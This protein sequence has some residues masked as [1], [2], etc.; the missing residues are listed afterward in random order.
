MAVAQQQIQT[1]NAELQ[2]IDVAEQNLANQYCEGITFSQMI[3]ELNGD[4]KNPGAVQ[5]L[6]S[7]L[8]Q[9]VAT[10]SNLA[11]DALQNLE[12]SIASSIT[13]LTAKRQELADASQQVSFQQL[14]D[15]VSKV[16]PSSPDQCPACKTPFAQATVN[17]ITM[18]EMSCKSSAFG[19]TTTSCTSA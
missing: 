13:D 12:K 3:Y 11:S 2:E 8:L 6:E 17:P 15:A 14:Y 9:P 19:V 1:N 7:E 4:E 16:Q 10:K 18:Q 5:K